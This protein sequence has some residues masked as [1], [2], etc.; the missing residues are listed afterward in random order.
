MKDLSA[1]LADGDD[2]D[3]A[4]AHLGEQRF[5]DLAWGSGD[6]NGVIGRIL[7]PAPTAI[8]VLESHIPKL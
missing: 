2:H 8:A 6:Q 1:I 4:A 3:T 7:L 5:G